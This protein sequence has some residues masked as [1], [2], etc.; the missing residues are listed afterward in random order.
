MITDY[1]WLPSSHRSSGKAKWCCVTVI[2][3]QVRCALLE[4]SHRA[5]VGQR[6]LATVQLLA[7]YSTSPSIVIKVRKP[8]DSRIV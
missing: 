3:L 6:A 5:R 4:Y 7:E 8:P 2:K 1:L